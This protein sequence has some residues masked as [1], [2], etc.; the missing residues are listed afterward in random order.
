MIQQMNLLK[1]WTDRLIYLQMPE[2]SG[3]QFRGG[4]LCP[5][6]IKIHG[7]SMDAL[8]PFLYM[9]KV[10]GEEK[11]KKAADE[12]FWWSE[13]NVT[14]SDG[15]MVNDPNNDWRG[16]TV[17]MVSQLAESLLFFE[18]LLG[19][20]TRA[21]ARKRLE[22]SSS[23]LCN[24]IDGLKTNVNY[25]F[26]CGL[27]LELAG[28]YLNNDGFRKKGKELIYRSIR[29]IGDDGLIFGEGKPADFIT[30]KGC[31]PVDIGYNGEESIPSLV[32][33]S[34]STGDEYIKKIAVSVMEAHMDFFL[35]DGGWDNSFG[36]RNSK[37]TYWGSRTSD[38]C[39]LAYAALGKERPEFMEVAYRNMMLLK[40]CTRDGLLY[41]GP[42]YEEAGEEACVH[43]TI[44]HA[45]MLAICSAKG[46]DIEMPVK[47]YDFM[48]KGIRKYI[49]DQV[50]VVKNQDWYVS[51]SAVDYHYAPDSTPGG[52]SIGLLW[53][54]QYGPVLAATM[55]RYYL[56][57]DANMQIPK[58]M[59][60]HCQ[61]PG[62]QRSVGEQA[63][64]S[65]YDDNAEL[66]T[67]E[68]EGFEKIVVNGHLSSRDSDNAYE[69]F[70]FTYSVMET[71][72][73][74]TGRTAASHAILTLPV[75]SRKSDEVVRIANEEIK[76]LSEGKWLRI[77]C[78]KGRLRIRGEETGNYHREF[79][80]VGGF[81][82]LPVYAELTED[83]EIAVELTAGQ[84]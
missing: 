22:D 83:E 28:A 62:I 53:N 72:C 51:C 50:V 58:S 4:I 75:I 1:D 79:H 46:Y 44:C 73:R 18:D 3:R 80:P 70:Q 48:K 27:A 37:W 10:T 66:E 43:H 45:K 36:T 19:G 6:C 55:T 32:Q 61:T 76:I 47:S 30:R 39:Q 65:V 35:P 8:F 29:Y 63:G 15:S 31:R 2:S 17:F 60:I 54:R 40:A 13:Y 64:F 59:P 77:R 33:Y 49:C 81:T 5:A 25:Y 42:M 41:G 67:M 20:K 34:L 71:C 69:R 7:R 23:Y 56:L 82:Y 68:S 24:M 78:Q 21:A 38:G 57:E 84:K 12:L 9:A 52:G 16:I 26:G 74:I 14:R 11:Y